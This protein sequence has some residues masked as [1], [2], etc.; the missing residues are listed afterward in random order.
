VTRH[1]DGASVAGRPALY[2]VRA[3]LPGDLSAA[4]FFVVAA[5]LL[6]GSDVLMEGVGLNETRLGLVRLLQS[7]GADIRLATRGEV[8]GEPVGDL[9]VLYGRDFLES[10]TLT[11]AG[12]LVANLID[13]VPALAVLGTQLRGGLVLRDA[14]EL[15]V[16]ESD[17]IAGVV[18]NLR[19]MG[20]AAAERPDGMDVPGGQRLRGAAIATH[21]DHRIAMAF[22]IAGLLAE[23]GCAL[24]DPAC[25]AVSFPEFFSRLDDVL[26]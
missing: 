19:R 20:V 10:D 4:A 8:G 17:R 13:E 5:L 25:A 22:A 18:E 24:D 11:V 9:R 16:K 2:A 12:D 7:R 14:A 3:R 1:A 15:R 21:G 23:G 6:P 26:V